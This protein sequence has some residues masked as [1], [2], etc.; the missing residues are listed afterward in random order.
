M[1]E[2]TNNSSLNRSISHSPFEIV[3]ESLPRKPMDLVPLPMDAWPIIEADAFSEHIDD[4]QH[5]VQWKL[6]SSMKL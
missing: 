1:A 2:F 4:I 6:F 3:T 5:H